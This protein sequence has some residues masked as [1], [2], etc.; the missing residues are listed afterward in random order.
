MVQVTMQAE[1]A[2][3]PQWADALQKANAVRYARADYK[4]ELKAGERTAKDL[5]LDPPDLALDVP[6]HEVLTWLPGIKRTRALRIL[7]GL[8]YAEG[9]TLGRLGPATRQRIY[10]RIQHHQ[11]TYQ[12]YAAAHYREAAA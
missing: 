8:V 12:R 11:P 6:V 9:M 3:S 10:E 7:S 4:R 5:L 1:V 2:T